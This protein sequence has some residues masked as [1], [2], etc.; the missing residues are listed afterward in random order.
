MEE[1]HLSREIK[2]LRQAARAF[3]SVKDVGNNGEINY[4]KQKYMFLETLY[5]QYV[6]N[7]LSTIN[8]L[9]WEGIQ[10]NDLVLL[11]NFLKYGEEEYDGRNPTN[12]YDIQYLFFNNDNRSNYTLS[13]C[14]ELA[15]KCN[16]GYLD[17][18]REYSKEQFPDELNLV[19]IIPHIK[20]AESKKY[21]DDLVISKPKKKKK[22]K[23]E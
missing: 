5:K 16:E 22:K 12:Q 7:L 4:I 10:N 9:Y 2:R 14:V 15:L 20:Q 6:I 23:M 13:E 11:S 18:L 19:D 17:Y 21:S 8:T 3:Q 1:L